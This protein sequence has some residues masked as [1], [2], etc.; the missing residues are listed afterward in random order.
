[1]ATLALSENCVFGGISLGSLMF[2]LMWAFWDAWFPCLIDL[3]KIDLRLTSA[4][5]A[6]TADYRERGAVG[7]RMALLFVVVAMGI[8]GPSAICVIAILKKGAGV[9][10]YAYSLLA[11]VLL[12]AW[13][14]VG[15][16]LPQ[17]MKRGFVFRIRRDLVI[18]KSFAA[19]L[20]DNWP[21]EN[22]CHP[23]IGEFIVEGDVLALK[24]MSDGSS[25][26]ERPGALAWRLGKGSVCID[27]R[28]NPFWKVEYHGHGS[29]PKSYTKL[30]VLRVKETL[31]ELV[32]LGGDWFLV[33]YEPCVLVEERGNVACSDAPYGNNPQQ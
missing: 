6:E 12:V 16:S 2:V 15:L 1:M 5:H 25:T 8:A 24:S 14:A 28:S 27:I 33:R 3:A 7:K 20:V 31:V 11:V 10:W 17:I 18:F 30:P 13:L 29:R 23:S 32:E 21:T 22:G 19:P 9:S 4:I 26:R